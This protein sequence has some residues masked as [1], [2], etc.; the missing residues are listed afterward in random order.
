MEVRERI[1]IESGALFGKYGIRSMTMDTLAE[2]MGIS[3]R[4]IYERFKDKDT[5]LTEVIRFYKEERMK[6]A[7]QIID[8]ST[9]VIEAM[10]RIMK[11]TISQLERMNPVFFHDF[12]KYHTRVYRQMA[13]PGEIRDMTV[14][15]KML[16]TGV[17]QKVFR[18]GIHIDI[19]NRALH[20]MFDLFGHESSL[21][22]E[23]Y[24]H[25]E[26]F[27]HIIIPYLRGI[28]TGKGVEL[29]EKYRNILS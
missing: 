28:S 20:Q 27:D 6:E 23:G 19:V 9:D 12:K 11:L 10:F 25:R 14:T 5:L 21:I 7:L 22:G 2:E 18:E 16:E 24:H 3:K 4:T 8:S 29:L 17:R 15:R 26:L 13:D 1:I